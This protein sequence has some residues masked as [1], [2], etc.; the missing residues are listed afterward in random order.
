[1]NIIYPAGRVTARGA[2]ETRTESG[3]T[4]LCV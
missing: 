4:T 3:P 1:M 2:L